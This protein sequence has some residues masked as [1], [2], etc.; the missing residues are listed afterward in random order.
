M[1]TFAPGS[2]EQLPI[3]LNFISQTTMI[4]LESKVICKC[5]CALSG[6]K[7]HH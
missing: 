2:V 4:S 1:I 7:I 3:V 5:V 6:V